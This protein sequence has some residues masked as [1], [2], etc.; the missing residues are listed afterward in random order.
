M[1]MAGQGRP[2]RVFAELEGII[3]TDEIFTGVFCVAKGDRT[4][5]RAA[6]VCSRSGLDG[7][8]SEE[9]AATT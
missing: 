8:E 7:G 6:D 1:A 2:G 3:K 9:A 4:G 5:W